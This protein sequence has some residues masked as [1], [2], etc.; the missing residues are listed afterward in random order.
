M[1]VLCWNFLVKIFCVFLWTCAQRTDFLGLMHELLLSLT[2]KCRKLTWSGSSR[3]CNGSLRF[4]SS[5]NPLKS[6]SPDACA[7]LDLSRQRFLLLVIDLWSTYGFQ[8]PERMH[9]LSR[10]VTACR[11]FA[12]SSRRRTDRLL[13]PLKLL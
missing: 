2:T 5:Y 10:C 13:F 12:G 7:L 3:R 4:Y 11:M 8:V 9:S 6:R 1:L